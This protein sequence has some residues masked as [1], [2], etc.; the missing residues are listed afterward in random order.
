M[1]NLGYEK[2]LWKDN[3]IL[4]LSEKGIFDVFDFWRMK[5]DAWFFIER[6]FFV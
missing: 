4:V 3:L 5:Y 2:I 1:Q 6:F